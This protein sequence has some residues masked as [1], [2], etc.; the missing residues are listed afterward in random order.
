[1][2]IKSA[3]V[4]DPRRTSG[5]IQ[6]PYLVVYVDEKPSPLGKVL[7]VSSP[8]PQ[9]TFVQHG[10]FWHVEPQTNTSL[11]E[12]V[13][14][15][16]ANHASPTRLDKV[17]PVEVSWDTDD[18]SEWQSMFLPVQRA[19]S[20][21]RKNMQEY[22]YIVSD[23]SARHGRIQWD[24]ESRPMMCMHWFGDSICADDR[25]SD[26]VNIEGVQIPSCRDHIAHTRRIAK[27]LRLERSKA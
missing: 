14:G 13:I 9:L 26:I 22:Q 21:I 25:V 20:L 17:V 12:E 6:A 4:I 8:G 16:Y 3:E 2:R 27:N 19:R 15:G 5:A 24:L 23:V 10:P 18:G 1:M 7:T 11:P